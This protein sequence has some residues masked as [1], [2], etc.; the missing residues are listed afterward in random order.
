VEAKW[1]N[2][3]QLA[4]GAVLFYHNDWA[5]FDHLGFY[6]TRKITTQNSPFFWLV[7]HIVCTP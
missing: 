6:K 3:Y 1:D 2:S 7:E 5:R 4:I